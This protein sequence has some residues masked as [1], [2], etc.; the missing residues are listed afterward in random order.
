VGRDLYGAGA[1]AP[2]GGQADDDEQRAAVEAY[3]QQAA[4]QSEIERLATDKE[5]TGV[6]IGA[7]AINPVN[8][9][10]I[11]IWIA[12]YVMMTYGTG[13]IMAVP[14]HDERDFRL[15]AQVR[16]AH[17]PGH[18][19]ARRLAKSVVL[20]AR[21][22]RAFAEALA[23]PRA[24]PS[25]NETGDTGRGCTSPEGDEPIDR[26]AALLREHLRPGYWVEVVGARWLFIFEDGVPV[27]DSVEAD[28]GHPGPLP[29]GSAG[30]RATAR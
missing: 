27:L 5:K 24:S 3:R 26:Y 19:S 7:Y 30:D 20:A 22:P 13:A 15:C 10:R 2:A 18:R 14:A 11:P 25:R 29:G 4:R 1:G 21:C 23:Q 8:G 17:H 9:A 12:D 6:F 16:P 28:A